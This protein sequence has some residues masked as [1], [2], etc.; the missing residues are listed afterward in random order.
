MKDIELTIRL[1]DWLYIT[2]FGTF[3]SL[4]FSLLRYNLLGYSLVD[5]TIFGVV[6]GIFITVISLAFVTVNNRWVLPQIRPDL[7]HRVS[8]L[9]S[10]FAGFIGAVSTFGV[11]FLFSIQVPNYV[12]D[13]P[14]L[15][16]TVFGVFTHVVGVIMYRFV[17]MRNEKEH[18]HTL[19]LESRLS[20]LETQLNPHFLFNALNSIAELINM[21]EK[22]AEQAVVQL[23]SFLRNSME[24]K[25][26]ITLQDELQNVK[27]Y[28]SIE[29]IRFNNT[30]A[31]GVKPN[32]I[33]VIMVPKF[34]IQLLVENALKHSFNPQITDFKIDITVVDD[35]T[36]L[37]SN[38]GRPIENKT[39]GIGLSNLQERLD[40]LLGGHVSVCSTDPVC[41]EVSLGKR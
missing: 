16:A 10:F 29:N 37:V 35:T 21:E 39:F 18:L 26:L 8:A 3:F 7:W 28:I 41:Y 20:S 24:E 5:G 9:L 19:L 1:K 2:A 40:V 14:F 23:S 38:N 32:I 34:S 17:R 22:K 31:L 27:D 13:Y 25:P 33:P 11:M 4:L 36:I 12:L 6:L 15:T 30:I